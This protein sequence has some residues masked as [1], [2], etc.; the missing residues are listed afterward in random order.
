M[1]IVVTG[2]TGNL[3]RLVVAGLLEKVP[4]SEIAAVVRD[5]GKAAGLAE[6]GVELRIAD[7][8][9]PESLK[10]AF[11]AGDK[12]L[13]ISGSEVG[14]RTVQHQAVIDAAKEAGVTLLAYTGVLGGPKADLKLAEEHK[15]TEQAI[16]D[17]G[18]PYVFLRNGWYSDVYTENLARPL[19][20]GTIVGSAGEGRIA[21]A[22][23]ADYAAA[24]VAVLTGTGHENKAYELCGDVA[25]SLPEYAAEV[26][27]QSGKTVTYS[28]V[29]A[30]QLIDI[31]KG[32]GLPAELAEIL[33]DADVAL[34]RG[35][36]AS[37]SDDLRRLIGRPSTPIADSIAAALA[38][39]E[40]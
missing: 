35:V 40:K 24:A 20:T 32:A 16:L 25:W 8:D 1:S 18:L 22:P 5:E 19:A 6:Q 31:Y 15:Y 34:S 11:H 4:A 10:A 29:P 3:G 30:E 36:L 27:R 17:S 13:L 28:D 9:R 23:R 38:G 12:V 7:Y 21:S 14:K 39:L 37:E 26:S 2:A 33:A